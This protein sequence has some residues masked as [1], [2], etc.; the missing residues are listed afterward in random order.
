MIDFLLSSFIAAASVCSTEIITQAPTTPSKNQ[1]YSIN[2]AESEDESIK[3]NLIE[4][5][6]CITFIKSF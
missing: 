4:T 2:L 5:C 3:Q 1:H 6:V